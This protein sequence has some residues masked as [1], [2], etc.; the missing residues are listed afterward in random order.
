MG[1]KKAGAGGGGKGTLM[2]EKC[3]D[4]LLTQRAGPQVPS[5]WVPWVGCQMSKSSFRDRE[6]R[7][8]KLSRPLI[9]SVITGKLFGFS[10]PLVIHT[11]EIRVTISQGCQ[12]AQCKKTA[13][14]LATCLAHNGSPIT[15]II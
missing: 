13:E 11:T 3:S 14:Q 2:N 6:I 12:E 1:V 7:V 15:I 10:D 9:S 5:T 8:Q 4:T